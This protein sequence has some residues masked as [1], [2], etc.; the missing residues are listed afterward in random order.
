VTAPTV[1]LDPDDARFLARPRL[2]I[3]TTAQASGPWP[4]PVPVWFEWTGT[5]AEMFTGVQS[6]KMRRLDADPRASLL[7]VNDVGEAEHW[8]ALEGRVSV[9][10]DG[11]A[12][13]AE[14][15]AARYWDL[16]DPG[17]AA[18][19]ET[20]KAQ[21]DSMVRLVLTPERLRRYAA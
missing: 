9:Q 11:V 17:H 16:G 14:R 12:E 18:T 15:L 8:V 21:A 7:V 19:V 6:P 10:R 13:L 4:G 2:G 20:W 5:T 1:T 3:F